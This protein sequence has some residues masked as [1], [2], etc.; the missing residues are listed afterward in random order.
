MNN[1]SSGS[2]SDVS[3]SNAPPTA[4]PPTAPI[5]P[6]N[7]P[8]RI[9]IPNTGPTPGTERLAMSGTSPTPL[10]TPIAPPTTAPHSLTRARLLSRLGGNGGDLFFGD[11]GRKN[12]DSGFLN[13][14]WHKL[15]GAALCIGSRFEVTDHNFHIGLLFLDA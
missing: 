4:P 6:N 8:A 5:A 15:S 13:F 10:A 9:P 1:S 3:L 11:L 14:Q 12:I 2:P 7:V